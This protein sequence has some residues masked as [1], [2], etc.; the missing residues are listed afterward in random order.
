MSAETVFLCSGLRKCWRVASYE[1]DYGE[2][3]ELEQARD[4]LRQ[5]VRDNPGLERLREEVTA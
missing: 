4:F 5:L 2:F 1:R 3:D